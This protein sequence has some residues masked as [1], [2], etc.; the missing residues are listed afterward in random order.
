M[1]ATVNDISSQKGKTELIIERG[2]GITY[3]GSAPTGTDPAFHSW[4]IFI[5]K[6]TGNITRKLYPIIDGKKIMGYELVWDDKETYTY[7]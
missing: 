1:T 3:I 6:T 2:T 5:L 7:E 4:K